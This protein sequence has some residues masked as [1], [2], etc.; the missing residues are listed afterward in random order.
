MTYCAEEQ[1]ISPI[2]KKLDET[3]KTCY[4]PVSVLTAPSKIYERVMFDR[5]C[6][7]LYMKLSL[8]P[9]GYLKGH[10][11][12]TALLKMTEDW[13]ASLD[14]C[15]AVAAVAID[16]SKAFVIQSATACY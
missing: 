10:S 15:E 4:R 7:E 16:L 8:N 2:F 5:V 12:C 11:C 6:V 9:S 3:D 13:R 1:D 14:R